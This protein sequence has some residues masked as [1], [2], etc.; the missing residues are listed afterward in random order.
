V[1]RF[2]PPTLTLVLDVALSEVAATTVYE[3]AYRDDK[4]YL[5]TEL[6]L[7]AVDL[8]SAEEPILA[9]LGTD[10][11]QTQ[12][13]A[14]GSGLFVK[15]EGKLHAFAWDATTVKATTI[16]GG[17]VWADA[18]YLMMTEGNVGT[19]RLLR[20]VG[21]GGDSWG[22]EW[23]LFAETASTITR[24]W[25]ADSGTTTMDLW[26]GCD[27]R[28]VHCDPTATVEVTFASGQ[29]NAFASWRGTMWAAGTI[30]GLWWRT[31]DGWA[32]YDAL[33]GFASILDM[34]VIGD[35]LYVVGIGATGGARVEAFYV[36]VAGDFQCGPE[37]PDVLVRVLDYAQVQE[38]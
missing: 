33:S 29:V 31:T 27:Q 3:A 38:A 9:K 35:R 34:A 21:T 25:R 10:A 2:V 28:I 13:L 23:A 15:Q 11:P 7:L 12:G 24:V 32:Q 18:S 30:G 22:G 8:D 26:L 14:S 20:W 37:P 5:G 6:G 16:P 1:Y 17:L 4:V 19:D 36:D